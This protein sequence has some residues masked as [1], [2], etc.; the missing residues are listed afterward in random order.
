VQPRPRGSVSCRSSQS[1]RSVRCER[2]GGPASATVV[3]LRAM[4]APPSSGTPW[5]GTRPRTTRAAVPGRA[6][7]CP[8]S[9]AQQPT[10]VAIASQRRWRCLAASACRRRVP[11]VRCAQ[12]PC[13]C[14]RPV[15][16][17]CRS[18]L[19]RR[20]VV[21]AQGPTTQKQGSRA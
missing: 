1:S 14:M 8:Q 17:G 15:Y 6:R 18:R 20:L 16:S 5:T 2:D 9:T 19:P 13:V 12:C 21:A 11:R 10:V 7:G 3:T 4:S